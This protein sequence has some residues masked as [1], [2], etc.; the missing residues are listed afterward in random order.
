VTRRASARKSRISGQL[1]T[2]QP[3]SP[4]GVALHVGRPRAFHNGAD[5]GELRSQ[6]DVPEPA[7]ASKA[8]EKMLPEFGAGSRL[9]PF[10]VAEQRDVLEE[11]GVVALA[12]LLVQPAAITGRID[13]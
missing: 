10:E 4:L 11:L 13:D 12:D 3:Q 9:P 7:L 5:A 2:K 1:A 8:T 6:R